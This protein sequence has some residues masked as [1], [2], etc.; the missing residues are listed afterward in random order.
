MIYIIPLEHPD[1]DECTEQTI[2]MV[3]EQ[4]ERLSKMVKTLLDMSE[5]QSCGT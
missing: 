2:T 5:L 3:T 1:N 4:N